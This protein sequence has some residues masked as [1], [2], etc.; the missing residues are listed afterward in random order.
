MREHRVENQHVTIALE[1]SAPCF[2]R[3]AYAYYPYMDV[4]VNGV[5]VRPLQTVGGFIALELG[6]G[7]QRIEL[8]PRLS[9]LRRA[10]LWLNGLV[11][12]A[13]AGLALREYRRTI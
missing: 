6:Q 3:L 13:G 7:P 10:L 1:T 2:A 4:L 11:L 9:P 5:A 8:A 12:C